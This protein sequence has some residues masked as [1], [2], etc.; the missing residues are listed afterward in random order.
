MCKYT[1][2]NNLSSP[3]NE[4][5]ISNALRSDCGTKRSHVRPF[6]YSVTHTP[7][8]LFNVKQIVGYAT[9]HIYGG[10]R[11]YRFS[12]IMATAHERY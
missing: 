5:Y 4:Q 11:E 1:N 3:F 7:L 9:D 12:W 8:I 6:V 2:D 10:L